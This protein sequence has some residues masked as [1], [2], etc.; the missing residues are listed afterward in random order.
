MQSRRYYAHADMGRAEQVSVHLASGYRYIRRC[1]MSSLQEVITSADR[2]LVSLH[3]RNTR[4]YWNKKALGTHPSF[5]MSKLYQLGHTVYHLA[6]DFLICKMSVI[7]FS[8]NIG[9]APP[10]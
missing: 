9:K 10:F 5:T 7:I 4:V 2:N 3:L 6:Y 8:N 1:S